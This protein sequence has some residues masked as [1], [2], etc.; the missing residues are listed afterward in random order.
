MGAGNLFVF[1]VTDKENGKFPSADGCLRR[2]GQAAPGFYSSVLLTR[3]PFARR[4]DFPPRAPGSARILCAGCWTPRAR[5][6]RALPGTEP[7]RSQRPCAEIRF[8]GGWAALYTSVV[9]F[10]LL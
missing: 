5:W 1:A 8:G 9:S 10:M 6:K 7:P 3:K 4:Q 2:Y